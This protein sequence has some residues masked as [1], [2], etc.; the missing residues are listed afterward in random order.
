MD[1]NTITGLILIAVVV[2]GFSYF[3]RP[4]KA[5]Q[6]AQQKFNDSIARIQE[7]Q[8]KA[9][10]AAADTTTAVATKVDTT[11]SFYKYSNKTDSSVV[12]ENNKVKLTFSSKGGYITEAILKEYKGQDKKSPVVLFTKKD[13]M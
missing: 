11:S 13:V 5:Q 3:S 12:L 2:I 10:K 6:M 8:A 1:K 4:S 9:K 7:Q